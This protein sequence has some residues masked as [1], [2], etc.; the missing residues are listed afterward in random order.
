MSGQRVSVTTCVLLIVAGVVFWLVSSFAIAEAAVPA[1]GDATAALRSKHAALGRQLASNPFQRPVVL[2]STQTSTNVKGDIYA[3]TANAFAKVNSSLGEPRVW[4]EILILHQNTKYC[5]VSSEKGAPTLLMNVGKKFDQPLEDSFRLAFAWQ[6][7]EQKADYLRA[8]LSAESGPLSTKNYRIM[9]EAIPLEN[10][11]TFI[12][13]AYEYSFGMS[14]KLAMQVYLG[15]LGRNK[16]GFTV[17]GK[18]GDGQPAYVD[19]MR[20]L[21]ERNT[22]RYYLAIESFLGAL[23]VPERAQFEKR[24]N[25]WFNASERYPRQLH[26]LER[27]EYLGMKRKEYRRQQVGVKTAEAAVG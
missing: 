7:V 8:E 9:L 18:N 19:G 15:T 11:S 14:G 13:L 3:V 20:G 5:R 26:E 23:A 21:V 25:D 2:E 4:C 27:D 24:I 12:H 10:G 6:L 22:M 17:T 1:A 16:V